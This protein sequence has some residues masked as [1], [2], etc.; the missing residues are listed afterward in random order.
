V[1]AAIRSRDPKA[2]IVTAG[3]SDSR[4]SGAIRLKSFLKGLYRGGGSSAFK[5]LAINSYA[6][7]PTSFARL[8]NTTRRLMNRSGGRSDKI[9][10]SEVGWCDRGVRH[11]FCVGRARQAKYTRNAISL[12]K[13]KRRAWKLRGFVWFSW[14]DGRPYTSKD[15]WGN[16]TGLLTIG[17]AKK[18]AYRAFTRGVKPL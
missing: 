17:G 8:L 3:L 13:R 14:R 5:T 4:L 7:N 1:G 11:R 9:W 6:T 18:P 12:I 10:I 2:E 16:H 15:F